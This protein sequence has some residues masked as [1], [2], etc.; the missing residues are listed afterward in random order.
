MSG[1]IY[2]IFFHSFVINLGEEVDLE[3]HKDQKIV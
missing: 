1:V 2:F 3:K